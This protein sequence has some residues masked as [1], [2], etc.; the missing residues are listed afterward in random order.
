MA[1]ASA[2]VNGLVEDCRRTWAEHGGRLIPRQPAHGQPEHPQ[3][4]QD[5]IAA[6]QLERTHGRGDEHNCR[7]D[8]HA[9]CYQDAHP[10]V[11][12]HPVRAAC[13]MS[14]DRIA[15]LAP[16]RW[17]EVTGVMVISSA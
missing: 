9:E 6:R 3:A 8:Q 1:C 16:W 17:T 14:A 12:V 4:W 15:S 2:Q 13:E 10:G 5:P 7:G 11:K